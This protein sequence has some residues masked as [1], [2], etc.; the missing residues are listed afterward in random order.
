[1]KN[2]NAWNDQYDIISGD[3]YIRRGTGSYRS[4]CYPAWF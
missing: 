1:M 2:T 4:T 3:G